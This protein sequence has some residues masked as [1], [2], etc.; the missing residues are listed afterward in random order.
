MK[1][2][3]RQGRAGIQSTP[4]FKSM[5]AESHNLRVS[6]L[7]KQRVQSS[8]S[9]QPSHPPGRGKSID[10]ILILPFFI[11][12]SNLNHLNLLNHFNL[13]QERGTKHRGTSSSIFN[14]NVHLHRSTLIKKLPL[15]LYLH[16]STSI[17]TITTFICQ[18]IE[19]PLATPSFLLYYF[20]HFAAS[21]S[22]GLRFDLTCGKTFGNRL[23][24]STSSL[25][26]PA[27]LPMEFS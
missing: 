11:H 1:Q 26:P 2:K 17:R 6:L 21:P 7:Q 24:T 25:N 22:T 23:Y 13:I 12:F 14:T 5:L 8:N 19:N 9:S 18:S 20:H 3:R 27:S 10:S 16:F 15:R 4:R